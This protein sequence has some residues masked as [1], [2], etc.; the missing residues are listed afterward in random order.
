MNNNHFAINGVSVAPGQRASIDLTVGR[1][2]T[3]SEITMPVQVVHGKKPG[4]RLFVCAAIHGDE[5]NGVEII[6]RLLNHPALKRLRGVLIAVPVVNIHGFINTSR[7]LPDRRDLNRSFP[8]SP[9]GSLASRLAHLFM[10]EVVSN[11]TH[12]IDLHTAAIHRNNLPQIR[13]DLDNTNLEDLARAFGVPVLINA[14]GPD[15]SLRRVASDQGVPTL[16]YEAGEALR[17][18]ETSIRAGVRGIINMMRHLGMLPASSS[19][20]RKP[21]EPFVA[22]STTWIRSPESGICR[23]SIPLGARVARDDKLGVIAD[24]F[25]EKECVVTSPISGVVIGRTNLPLVNEGDALFHIARFEK[26]SE[27][28]EKVEA[29][30]EE[31]QGRYPETLDEPPLS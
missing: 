23:A 13:G 24:P 1:L 29:F 27:V 19:K 2:Y 17:F 4:Y 15:G 5:I 22:R 21:F 28:A 6:R 16:I 18:D 8:G 9:E 11:S 20:K 25:G 14:A 26:L 3:H 7:Y 31:T 10:T 30:Q 12:G